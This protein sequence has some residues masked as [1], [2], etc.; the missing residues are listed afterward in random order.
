[1]TASPPLA[2]M[3]RLP[4]EWAFDCTAM[5]SSPAAGSRAM[6][7]K[8]PSVASSSS[9]VAAPAGVAKKTIASSIW[10]RIGLIREL[11]VA[12]L[13]E[14]L[15]PALG[16]AADEGLEFRR[17]RADRADARFFEAID[18]RRVGIKVRDLAMDLVDD[19]RR[20]ARRRNESDPGRA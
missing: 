20:G 1:M 14:N 12:V 16:L 17:R 2:L 6:M 19:R 3:V 8:V 10:K 9:S 4:T 11:E 7:E 13:L 15:R 5:P 18:E